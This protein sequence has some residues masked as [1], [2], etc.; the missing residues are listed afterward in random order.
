[1]D[2]FTKFVKDMHAIF[3]KHKDLNQYGCSHN[4]QLMQVMLGLQEEVGE[5]SQ[6]HSKNLL[7]GRLIDTSEV[8][9]ELGDVL[10][11]LVSIGIHYEFTLEDIIQSNVDKISERKKRICDE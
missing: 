6:I 2:H 3:I 8:L 1:M 11:Y 4:V 9:S 5:L 10:H 7:Y